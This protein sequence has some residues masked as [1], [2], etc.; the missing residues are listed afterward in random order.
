M[1]TD[2]IA[3]LLTRIRNASNVKK[4]EVSAPYSKI[5]LAIAEILVRKGYLSGVVVSKDTPAQLLL[6]LK[7][8]G[9]KPAISSLK[10]VSKPGGRCYV[11][12]DEI[13]E[14]L[15]GYGMSILSTPQGLLTNREAK[16]A[17]V[18]GELICEVY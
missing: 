9:G 16:K 17:Q 11:K 13:R 12:K 14:V 15:N 3:D 10:R 2:P 18:G 5:K 8:S 4:K 7:Y 1:M 6:A